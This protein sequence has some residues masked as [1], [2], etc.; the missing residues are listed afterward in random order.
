MSP[1]PPL[2]IVR[3]SNNRSTRFSVVP[4]IRN[5]FHR[6]TKFIATRSPVVSE[7]ART[8]VVLMMFSTRQPPR[9]D[10]SA[11]SSSG[12]PTGRGPAFT[13]YFGSVFGVWRRRVGEVFP[14]CLPTIEWKLMVCT[15]TLYPLETIVFGTRGPLTARVSLCLRLVNSSW[16]LSVWYCID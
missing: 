10:Q 14:S 15:C 5:S 7:A 1:V 8:H 6:R 9:S 2:S 16:H 13:R 4:N 3:H 12:S 11:G